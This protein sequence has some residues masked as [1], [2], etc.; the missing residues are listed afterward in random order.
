MSSDENFKSLRELIK[1]KKAKIGIVGLGYVG[2]LVAMSAAKSGFEIIGTDT[3]FDRQRSA[4]KTAQGLFEV[5]P[6]L[7]EFEQADVIVIAVPTPLS[8]IQEPD[9]SYVRSAANEVAKHHR[10][11]QLI[12]LESTTYPGTTEEILLPIFSSTGLEAGKDYCL[13]YSP[14][15]IDFGNKDRDIIDIPKL[16]GGITPTCMELAKIFYSKFINKVVSVSST[17]VAEM[18]KLLENIYRS[19]NVALVNELALLCDKMNIDVWEVINAASTKPFGF[20]TFNPGPGLGGHCIPI[21]PFYLSWKAK[22]YGFNTEFIE[23]A[24]KINHR[25]PFYV[26][27]KITKSLEENGK[28]LDGANILIIGMAYKKDVDDTR[29]SPA[30]KIAQILRE[31]RG[32]FSY[33]D[34]Y[35]PEI[36]LNGANYAS[37][38]LNEK[39]LKKA[40]LAVIVT[41]HSKLDYSL[42]AKSSKLIV[43]TRNALADFKDNKI[44][45]I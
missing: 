13:A 26:V 32:S 25:M 33:H 19:V 14:E 15:R 10:K 8:K 40:D 1:N 34:P 42:I 5:K 41:D 27:E 45:R 30:L 35:I 31:R 18:A 28:T 36:K 22:E 12:I 21:D 24:G 20:M 39:A 44:V 43:D 4:E 9:L 38:P 3:S 7:D 23:L 11:D 6:S 2:L 17:Q 16:V 29:E 37:V